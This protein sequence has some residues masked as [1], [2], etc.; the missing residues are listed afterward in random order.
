MAVNKLYYVSADEAA[1]QLGLPLL[2][3]AASS[4]A[5][6]RLGVRLSDHAPDTVLGARLYHRLNVTETSE[7]LVLWVVSPRETVEHLGWSVGIA[8][9]A[10]RTGKTA[11]LFDLDRSSSMRALVS[12]DGHPL[13]SPVRARVERLLVRAAA[14]WSSDLQGVRIALPVVRVPAG[15]PMEAPAEWVL[16]IASSLPESPQETRRI[17]TEVD[18]VVLT[19]GIRDHTRAEL[20]SM[21]SALSKAS[22][23]LLGLVAMGPV[24]RTGKTPLDRWTEPD[25]L[26]RELRKEK[27]TPPEVSEREEPVVVEEPSDSGEDETEWETDAIGEEQPDEPVPTSVDLVAGWQSTAQPK[28]GGQRLLLVFVVAVIVVGVGW[29]VS[30][31]EDLPFVPERELSS[32]A[33]DSTIVAADPA[34]TVAKPEPVTEE[35][36]PVAAEYEPGAAA[37]D[38]VSVSPEA[39]ESAADS[40]FAVIDSLQ[41]TVATAL[42]ESPGDSIPPEVVPIAVGEAPDSAVTDPLAA[43]IPDGRDTIRAAAELVDEGSAT[44]GARDSIDV[45]ALPETTES[46]PQVSES[47]VAG[48]PD[49]TVLETLLV[50]GETF[51]IPWLEDT[52]EEESTGWPDTFAIHVSSF[53][54]RVDSEPEVARLQQ[55]GLSARIVTVIIPGKGQWDRVVVGSYPDSAAGVA[56]AA[57][58]LDQGL[59]TYVQVLNHD[60]AGRFQ[61]AG[62]R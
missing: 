35:L 23:S 61:R 58:L 13:P 34:A 59:A 19:A 48:S 32:I 56:A 51:G 33:A 16:V 18:G 12:G 11:Y 31:Y 45:P 60:G 36:A 1:S 29:I 50:T 21:V 26:K 44:I 37:Q 52:I 6:P 49:T 54:S 7:P 24:P 15:E 55:A 46:Q 10:A 5:V 2:L 3:A 4:V 14:V 27:P 30:N 22:S 17:S 28:K 20:E 47:I 43:L 25:H 62:S 39:G 53:R 40:V 42:Q 38:S 57:R 8:E 9:H 41:G